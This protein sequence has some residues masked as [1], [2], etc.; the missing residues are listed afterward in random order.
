MQLI[1]TTPKKGR[2]KGR[3]ALSRESVKTLITLFR[4]MTEEEQEDVKR[5]LLA[6]FRRVK[7][8]T[9]RRPTLQ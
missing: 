2:K 8:K 1:I 9:V 3:R 5:Q 7:L 4:E 6:I